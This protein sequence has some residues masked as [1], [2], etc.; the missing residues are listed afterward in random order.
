MTWSNVT[1][2]EPGDVI[3]ILG[4]DHV[5]YDDVMRTGG[6][7]AWND[8]NPGNIVNSGEAVSYG[9]YPGKHNDIFAVFPDE[10]TGFQAVRRYLARRR[11]KTVL[12]VMKAYAPA[13]HGSNDP[14]RYAQQ[15]ADAMGVGTGTALA[16]L[17]DNQLTTFADAIR[18]VEG[19]RPGAAHG[20]D[21][22]P[23]DVAQWLAEHPSRPERTAAD[24][25]FARKG[26]VAEGVKNIQQR[27]NDLGCDPPLV[28]DGNFGPRTQEAVQRFQAD[29]GL[30][31]D[32]IVG[33]KTWRQLVG[34]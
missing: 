32:G 10:E 22:L 34:V 2:L 11:D 18:R 4:V 3:S 20:P 8:Q 9:A 33:N 28:V 14:Q 16:A 1:D 24:Q 13:G 7:I 27:L 31:A 23:G 29:N 26:T 21:D 19:W 15:V 6:S 12:E 30:T 17:D 25:P 5:F